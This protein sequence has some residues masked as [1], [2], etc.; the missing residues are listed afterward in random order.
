MQPLHLSRQ[1]SNRKQPVF[2]VEDF[3]C[4]EIGCHRPAIKGTQQTCN[5]GY[6]AVGRRASNFRHPVIGCRR[7]RSWIYNFEFHGDV[8]S[9]LGALNSNF[10]VHKTQLFRARKTMQF[11]YK[12]IPAIWY[13]FWQYNILFQ[14]TFRVT[15]NLKWLNEG[16]GFDSLSGQG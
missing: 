15:C 7:R 14:T 8:R 2:L 13:F 12:T 9:R 6:S 1:N 4:Q 3:R 11:C 16:R 5:F 10:A